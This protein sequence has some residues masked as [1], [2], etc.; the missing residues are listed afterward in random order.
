M[1]FNYPKEKKH[2]LRCPYRT[3]ARARVMDEIDK[4][5]EQ[6]KADPEALKEKEKENCVRVFSPNE[7]RRSQ[8]RRFLA[9][10]STLLVCLCFFLGFIVY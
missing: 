5:Q 7:V 6:M 8:L 3:C 10:I 2:A 1:V 4:V 9:Q